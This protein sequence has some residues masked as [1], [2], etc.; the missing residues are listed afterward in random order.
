MASVSRPLLAPM[1]P[2]SRVAVRCDWLADLARPYLR[3]YE[4]APHTGGGLWGYVFK[5]LAG[6]IRLGFFVGFLVSS[7]RHKHL[8]VDAPACLVFAFVQP[9]NWPIHRRLVCSD[10]SLFR[11][12]ARYISWLT[13]RKPQWQ[14]RESRLPALFRAESMR[15]WPRARWEHYARNFFTES[16]AL[17]VRSGLV[18][19]L[20]LLSIRNADFPKEHR[21]RRMS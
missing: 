15:S 16:L 12:T 11:K 10:K 20:L 1:T 4:V 2:D 3:G 14:F 19:E 21:S 13:P 18:R 5:R 8:L 7:E 9:V 17:L 6:G